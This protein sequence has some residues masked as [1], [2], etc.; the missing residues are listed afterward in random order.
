MT[1]A[2][3]KVS[4]PAAFQGSLRRTRAPGGHHTHQANLEFR[5]SLPSVP[6]GYL[7]CLNISSWGWGALAPGP[8][9]PFSLV[10][11]CHTRSFPVDQL[12]LPG[13]LAPAGLFTCL[14]LCSPKF[15]CREGAAGFPLFS[16]M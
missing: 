13:A 16:L 9:F 2:L 14:G 10:P 1:M 3:G 12:L 5:K 15:L 7:P 6:A 8:F 4:P 11:L